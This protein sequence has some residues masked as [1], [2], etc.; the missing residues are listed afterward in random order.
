MRRL[1]GLAFV[2]GVLWWLFGR[3]TSEAGPRATIGFTDGSAVTLE[4]SAPKL[5]PLLL[6]AAEATRA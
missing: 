3:R 5:D 1:F 2:G 6:I 4:S